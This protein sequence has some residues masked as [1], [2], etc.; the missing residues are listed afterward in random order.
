MTGARTISAVT[1]ATSA[2]SAF[3]SGHTFLH[4][5]SASENA[6]GTLTVTDVAATMICGGPDDFHYNF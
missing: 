3:A 6:D 2:C 4:L 5:T 1:S